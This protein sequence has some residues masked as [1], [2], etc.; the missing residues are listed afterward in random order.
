MTAEDGGNGAGARD[1]LQALSEE[2]GSQLPPAPVRVTLAQ[3]HHLLFENVRAPRGR[4][5][6]PPRL[7]REAIQTSRSIPAKPL[8]AGLR[9]DPE[10][11]AQLADVG[12]GLCSQADELLT[13]RLHGNLSPGHAHLL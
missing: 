7:V 5:P 12:L 9:A 4:M 3:G 6:R 8:V 11:P 10:T 13:L 1:I 2:Q